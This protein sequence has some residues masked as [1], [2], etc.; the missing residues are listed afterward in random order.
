MRCGLTLHAPDAAAAG[1]V[2]R[3]ILLKNPDVDSQYIR[4]WLKEFNEASKEKGLLKTFE[5][6]VNGT[7]HK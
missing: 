5:G 2:M 7:R 4:R 1:R 6:I 3:A